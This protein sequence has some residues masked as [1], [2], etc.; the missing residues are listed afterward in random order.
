MSLP[1]PNLLV[2]PLSASKLQVLE[3]GIKDAYLRKGA[4]EEFTDIAEGGAIDAHGVEEWKGDEG[5]G[6]DTDKED[7]NIDTEDVKDEVE[8]GTTCLTSLARSTMSIATE[9]DVGT[10]ED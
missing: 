1:A 3:N 8:G 10:D 4:K 9:E 7:S 6:V 5:E 2:D